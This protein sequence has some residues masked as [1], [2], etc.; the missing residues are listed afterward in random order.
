[1]GLSGILC[2]RGKQ[3]R[4]RTAR[5]KVVQQTLVSGRIY[6][7]SMCEEERERHALDSRNNEGGGM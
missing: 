3:G 2:P 1:M 5:S 7:T 4:L 6:A